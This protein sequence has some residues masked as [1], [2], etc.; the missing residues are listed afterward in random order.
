MCYIHYCVC[1]KYYIQKAMK[2]DKSLEQLGFVQVFLP[3]KLW[4]EDLGR[5]Q[6]VGLQRVGH[7]LA[8][9]HAHKH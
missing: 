9:E 5:L 6:S 7:D 8:T 2:E 3:G 1:I 4:T